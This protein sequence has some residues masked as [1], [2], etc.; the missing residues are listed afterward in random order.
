MA[1]MAYAGGFRFDSHLADF[2]SFFSLLF[3]KFTCYLYELV[4]GFS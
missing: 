2:T 1:A 4:L 3:F